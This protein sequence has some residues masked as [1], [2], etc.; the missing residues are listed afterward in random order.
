VFYTTCA[1]MALVGAGYS[2]ASW[3]NREAV[4]NPIFRWSG[5]GGIFLGWALIG[6]AARGPLAAAG[7][8]GSIGGLMLILFVMGFASS[9]WAI[10]V[11]AFLRWAVD[12]GAVSLM[13]D[14][15][16]KIRPA[17]DKAEAAEARHDFTS[18]EAL[19]RDLA[20]QH[21]DEPEP[22]RRL[23]ELLV[24]R[25]DPR[26]SV[27]PMERAIRIEENPNEKFLLSI[28]LSEILADD[29]HDAAS[30]AKV[31]AD[32]IAAFPDNP[33]VRFAQERLRL[34]RQRQT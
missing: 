14:N 25:G 29:A 24:K 15:R 11:I 33:G 21:P 32:L 1:V 13:S 5:V 18:A 31:L 7:D 27:E 17:Y 20:T 12:R 10:F 4:Y 19:Y 26:S 9:P 6:S 8:Q 3:I 22:L 23:A 16:L 28:R 30:A 34:L 2:A